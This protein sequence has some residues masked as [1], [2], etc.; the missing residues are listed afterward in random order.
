VIAPNPLNSQKYE[1]AK[2]SGFLLTYDNALS[3]NLVMTAGFGWLGEINNQF[4]QT[5][6]NFPA[7]QGG[8]IPPYITW[9]GQHT[10]TKWG[11]QGAWLQSINRK[12]GVA[13]VNNWLWSRGRHTFNIGGEF[14]RAYQ[15]DNEEQ[16]AGGQFAFSQKTTSTPNPNDPNFG[17]YGSALRASCSGFLIPSIARTRRNCVSATWTSLRTFRTTSS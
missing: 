14:R 5:K 1:P 3:T 15:D 4:N 2:G 16:T 7:V 12:L 10:L 13:I 11:T 9:D 8:V 17:Q 6:Y